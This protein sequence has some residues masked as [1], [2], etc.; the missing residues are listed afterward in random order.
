M[1]KQVL[2]G[3]FFQGASILLGFLLVP[4]TLDYLSNDKEIY[5][6]WLM[7][8][9]IIAWFNFFDVG[10]GNGMRNKFAE[11]KAKGE[12]QLARVYV[13]TT[14]VGLS[15]IMAVVFLVLL[16]V[17][18]FVSWQTAYNSTIPEYQ[19]KLTTLIVFGF[20]CFRFVIQLIEKLLIADQRPSWS[21]AFKFFSN[22]IALAVI[23]ILT[24]YTEGSLVNLSLVLSVSPIIIVIFATFYFFNKDYKDYRPSFKLATREHFNSLMSLGGKFFLLQIGS[25]ILFLT[26]AVIIAQIDSLG[27]EAVTDYKLTQRYFNIP[28]IAFAII[29]N[30]LWSAFTDAYTRK[31]FDWIRN[32]VKK[33]VM[34]WGGLTVGII[35]MIFLAIP[36]IEL[37]TKGAVIPTISLVVMMGIF[38]I[39]LNLNA[40]F[41]MFVN[42]V[43]KIKLQIWSAYLAMI[44][45]IPLSIY[46]AKY[47]GWGLTGII[48]ATCVSIGIDVII[49]PIQYYK[50]INGTAKGI[51]NA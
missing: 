9:D 49:R 24:I 26:D 3:F 47:L 33:T 20:F 44:I 28:T 23:Y 46:F 31:D 38:Q 50:I 39:M 42:G 15:L 43:G 14:Y 36:F 8:G 27:P 17:I 45:N 12:H 13:S 48:A 2:L 25:L 22:V 10:L 37:W 19:L 51:W 7:L 29:T 21:K 30:T 6:V 18:P 11:A 35:I 32:T 34:L 16:A 4:I 1:K 40:I 41:V 5:G